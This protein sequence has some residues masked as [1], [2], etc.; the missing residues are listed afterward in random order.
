ITPPSET[1]DVPTVTT[2]NTKELDNATS[3]PRD[4]FPREFNLKSEE[5]KAHCSRKP[6]PARLNAAVE[7]DVIGITESDE[8]EGEEDLIVSGAPSRQSQQQEEWKAFL[9]GQT[10]VPMSE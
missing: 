9:K 8:E 2:V 6:P 7:I 10:A 4:S 3:L 1:R 5:A